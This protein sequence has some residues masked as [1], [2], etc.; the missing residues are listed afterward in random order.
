MLAVMWYRNP[1]NIWGWG[2]VFT[3]L[4]GSL[5]YTLVRRQEMQARDKAKAEA[6]KEGS[7][8]ET[9]VPMTAEEKPSK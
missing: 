6:E 3:V 5:L 8:D 7:V 4:G 1:V 9:K 2:S